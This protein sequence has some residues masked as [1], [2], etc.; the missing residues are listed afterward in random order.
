MGLILLIVILL[1][2]FGGGEATTDIGD[3][4]RVEASESSGWC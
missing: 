3:G 1:L 4:V 2:L